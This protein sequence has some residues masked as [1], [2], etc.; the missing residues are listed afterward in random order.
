MSNAF[1][2]RPLPIAAA[3]VAASGSSTVTGAPINLANDYAGVIWRGTTTGATLALDFDM[4]ADIDLDTIMLFGIT[5]TLLPDTSWRIALATAAQGPTFAGSNVTTGTGTGNYWWPPIA[6]LHA[7]S[8]MP[9]IGGGKGLWTKPSGGPP[10]FR[11]VRLGFTGMG[12]SAQ[13]EAARV[14]IGQRIQLERNFAFGGQFGV[15]DLG[16]LDFSPRG[17]LLR[18][19]SKKLRTVNIA[20]PATFRDEIEEKVQPLLELIGNTE[21]IALV[22]DPD[23]DAQR[24]NRMYFGPL[25]GEIATT[26]ARAGGGWEWRCPMVSLF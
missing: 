15:R 14:V 17:V 22:T 21:P 20:F 25:L 19:R 18:R 24:Q 6:A 10:L 16:S 26:Q 2:V 4:G 23:A 12:A 8:A 1:V 11:Y 13:I 7:G 5:G 9:V 3:A